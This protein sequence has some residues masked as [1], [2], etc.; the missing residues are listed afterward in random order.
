MHVETIVN[1]AGTTGLLNLATD[2][3]SIKH[4][5]L[6]AQWYQHERTLYTGF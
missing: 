6:I 4:E 5:R 1:V 3:R 2:A